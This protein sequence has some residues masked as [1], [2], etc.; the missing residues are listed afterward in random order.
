MLRYCGNKTY[1]LVSNREVAFQVRTTKT[2]SNRQRPNGRC[3]NQISRL[4]APARAS[5]V[6]IGRVKYPN[7]PNAS[8]RRSYVVGREPRAVS[9]RSR[10]SQT[11]YMCPSYISSL[12]ITT[13]NLKSNS[14]LIAVDPRSVYYRKFRDVKAHLERELPVPSRAYTTWRARGGAS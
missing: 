2:E 9:A 10:S 4:P 3:C 6:L 8:F 11:I 5:F 12:T 14:H 1:Y 13:L 7:P